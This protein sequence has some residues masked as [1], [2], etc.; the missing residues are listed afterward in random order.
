MERNEILVGKKPLMSYVLA[1]ITQL[2]ESDG[3]V[4]IKARGKTISKAVDIA[5]IVKNKFA[6]E[7]K[8]GEVKIGT[9]ELE[10]KE[11][12]KINVSTIEIPVKK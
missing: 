3:E 6:K 8:I 9:E 5:Q 2:S 11:G 10:A 4:V 1:V 7:A 12:G